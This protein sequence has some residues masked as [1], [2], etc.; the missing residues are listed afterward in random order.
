MAYATSSGPAC[1]AACWSSSRTAASRDPA[2]GS[3]REQRAQQGERWR[4]GGGQDVLVEGVVRPGALRGRLRAGCRRS[5][6]RRARW[7]RSVVVIGRR[8]RPARSSGA[9][10]SAVPDIRQAYSALSRSSSWWVPT[11]V[12]RPPDSSATRS[13]S[14]TVDGRCA[15]T[16]AVVVRAGPRR[17]AAST[18]ASVCTSSADSGSSSTRKRGPADH[19]PGQREPLPLAAGQAEALLADLGVDALRQRVHEVGLRDVQRARPAPPRPRRP[20]RPS[21]TFSPTRRREQRRLLE[22]D[23]DQFA[24]LVAGAARRCPR[25]RG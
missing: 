6:V 23:R 24:Q 20:G 22:G 9:A 4:P 5:S 1:T 25:R 16:S 10:V 17:S 19:R 7:R 11:A 14:S 18:S 2:R 13:A 15:T 21:A 3:G 12:I 8:S